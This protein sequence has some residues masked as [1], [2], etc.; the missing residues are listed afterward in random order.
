MS[1]HTEMLKS[2]VS[3][4]TKYDEEKEAKQ[5]LC[6]EFGGELLADKKFIERVL[7]KSDATIDA[8]I[9]DGIPKSKYSH[10][11]KNFFKLDEVLVWAVNSF[12]EVSD[13]NFIKKKKKLKEDEIDPNDWTGRKLKADAEKTEEQALSERLKR[14]SLEGTLVDKDDI[15][16]S[17]T[18][19]G[20]IY[21][22]NY[23]DDLK[24]LPVALANKSSDEITEFLDRHYEG[25]IEDM[26]KIANTAIKI[27]NE[28]IFDKIKEYIGEEE[29]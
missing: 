13:G 26:W 3:L 28:K 5:Y 27:E 12:E 2:I 15:D 22:A 23:R 14:K 10:N 19:I 17:M 1:N 11:K 8:Y 16:K 18:E 21:L 20:A 7:N 25:R 29:K 24:L 9:K 6:V 4:E